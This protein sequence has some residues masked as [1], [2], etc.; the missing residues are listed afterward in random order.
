MSIFHKLPDGSLLIEGRLD[1]FLEKWKASDRSNRLVLD[2][3][4]PAVRTFDDQ[5]INLT[6]IH[7]E[8]WD[9]VKLIITPLLKH[10]ELDHP[11]RHRLCEFCGSDLKVAKE[12]H[13][14]WVFRCPSCETSE[15]HAKAIVGGQMGA[16]EPEKL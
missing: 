3:K 11:S 4:R 6:T 2:D 9:R 1:H 16:G 5:G 8:A 12:L 13:D 10:G 15:I 14:S 7:P